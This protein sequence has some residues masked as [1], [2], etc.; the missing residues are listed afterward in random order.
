MIDIDELAIALGLGEAISKEEVE[1]ERLL[2]EEEIESRKEDDE[3]VRE[4]DREI[5]ESLDQTPMSL[6]SR[7]KPRYHERLDKFQ[8]YIDEVIV[9]KIPLSEIEWNIFNRKG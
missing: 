6:K 9:G 4:I 2:M 1:R 7:H 3:V 8:E 5:R